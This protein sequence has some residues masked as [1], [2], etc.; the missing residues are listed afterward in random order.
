M[1]TSWHY[2][3]QCKCGFIWPSANAT[4]FTT[5]G[6][7]RLCPDCGENVGDQ[8]EWNQ[9]QIKT[10]RYIRTVPFNLFDTKTWSNCWRMETKS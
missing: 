4:R 6:F 5:F 3:C 8:G 9:A 1:N 2:I 10:V 7:H